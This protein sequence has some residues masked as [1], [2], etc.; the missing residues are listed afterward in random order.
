MNGGSVGFYWWE[1]KKLYDGNRGLK[2]SQIRRSL[3]S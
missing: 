2:T 1:N 3:S